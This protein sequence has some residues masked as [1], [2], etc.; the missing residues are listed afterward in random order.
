MAGE[1][2]PG[3]RDRL[4]AV[5]VNLR[6]RTSAIAEQTASVRREVAERDAR[7]REEN[8]QFSRELQE[9][10]AQQDQPGAGQ[11]EDTAR[12]ESRRMHALDE[13]DDVAAEAT[14][15]APALPVSPA[16]PAATPPATPPSP[17][18][19]VAA[20]QPQWPTAPGRHAKQHGFLDEDDDVESNGWLRG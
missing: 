13:D 15:R 6:H 1:T 11:G 20:N 8:E 10:A 12:I 14:P 9:R 7:L 2:T 19:D 16:T 17:W 5:R 3:L 4:D 18:Y